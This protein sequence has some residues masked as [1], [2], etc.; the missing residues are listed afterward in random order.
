MASTLRP[1][2]PPSPKDQALT[3]TKSIVP[4]CD[5]SELPYSP[6]SP[7][8]KW[9]T[10]LCSISEVDELYE[11]VEGDGTYHG[12]DSAGQESEVGSQSDSDLSSAIESDIDDK[13][14]NDSDRGND[15]ENDYSPNDDEE[16]RD[17]SETEITETDDSSEAEHSEAEVTSEAKGRGKE[18]PTDSKADKNNPF[19]PRVTRYVAKRQVCASQAGSFGLLHLKAA[20][21]EPPRVKWIKATGDSTKTQL[22]ECCY[23]ILTKVHNFGK[24]IDS[25]LDDLTY[26][27]TG[28]F[29]GIPVGGELDVFEL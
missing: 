26:M 17:G 23:K 28:A 25:L 16:A 4:D 20:H 9:G 15:S 13:G 24:E 12:S 18:N 3:S 29:D 19:S 21:H 14:S 11:S 27:Y 7:P 10:K 2:I 1:L 22:E 6:G 8:G 5:D